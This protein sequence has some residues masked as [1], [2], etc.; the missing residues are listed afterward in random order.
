MI[1]DERRKTRPPF[2]S[3]PEPHNKK[4]IFSIIKPGEPSEA[5][6]APAASVYFRSQ[7]IPQGLLMG[8]LPAYSFMDRIH[9]PKSG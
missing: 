7:G 1:Q 4:I 2:L 9:S 5:A 3:Y 6:A 8:S